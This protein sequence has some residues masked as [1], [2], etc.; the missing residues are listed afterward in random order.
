MEEPVGGPTPSPDWTSQWSAPADLGAPRPLIPPP[1]IPPVSWAPS[2]PPQRPRRPGISP[3]GYPLY[4]IYAIGMALLYVAGSAFGYWLAN[5]DVSSAR[6]TREEVEI[7]GISMLI[8][9]VP[10]A[11]LFVVAALVPKRPWGWVYG[12]VMICIGL[13]SCCTWPLTIPLLIKWIKPEM[14]RYFGK[15]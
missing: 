9:G 6:Y 2:P 13:T 3:S 8:V 15:R 12:L 14:K 5:S 11:L 10:L 4:L 7:Q 1:P